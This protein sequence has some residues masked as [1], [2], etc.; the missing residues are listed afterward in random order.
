VWSLEY[1]EDAEL[2]FELIFEHLFDSYVE[3]GELPSEALEHAA[4]RVHK[5][6]AEIDRLVQTPLIG[7]L[8]DSV[9]P[10]IRFVRR[11][12]AAVWF[13]SAESNRTITVAAIFFG[14][15]DHVTHMLARIL[16]N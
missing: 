3:L 1:A 12:N 4:E 13:L 8:Q 5:L 16:T 15:Q 11:D 6:R 9:S 10:W 14:A 2:D 7:T